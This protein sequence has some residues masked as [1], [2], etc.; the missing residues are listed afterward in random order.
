[1]L[2]IDRFQIKDT[3]R[4]TFRKPIAS[5]QLIMAS[6]LSSLSGLG[7]SGGG[8]ITT[9]GLLGLLS[10]LSKTI[11]LVVA[12]FLDEFDKVLDG[13]LAAVLHRLV[14]LAGG[15]ELD[16]REARDRFGHIVGSG[17]DLGNDDLLAK[18]RNVGVQ[19]TKLLVLGSKGLAVSTPGS[20]VLD[21]DILLV[22]LHNLL[23]VVAND[24]SDGSLL[25]LGDGLGL[26]AGFNLAGEDILDEFANFLGVKLLVL[27]VRVLGVLGALSDFLDSESGELLGLKVEI[28][29]VGTEEL[30][31][32]GHDVDL[33]TV[34]LSDGAEVSSELLTL[35]G[36]LGEDVG[37]GN[38]GL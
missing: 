32:K 33:S 7:S 19:S 14:F 9:L 22:F 36:G 10:A 6:L 15:V 13:T 31:I 23:E 29:G 21:K 25:G 2:N 27:V 5:L 28:A 26:D 8:L 12:I 17:V 1:M 3:Y 18:L 37:K 4:V 30:S 38:S 11:D 20:V 24:D 35:L 34:L 16:G